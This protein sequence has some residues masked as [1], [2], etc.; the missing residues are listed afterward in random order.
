M[1]RRRN[2]NIFSLIY[3]NTF[4]LAVLRTPL[5]DQASSMQSSWGVS[6]DD[7]NV[8]DDVEYEAPD[9]RPVDWAIVRGRDGRFARGGPS[10]SAASERWMKRPLEAIIGLRDMTDALYD[11]LPATPLG[12][13]PYIM[14]QHI[15]CALILAFVERWQPETNTVHMPWGEMTIMLYDV[16]RILGIAI[17]GSLPAEPTVTTRLTV[18]WKKENG[19]G[20]LGSLRVTRR[21]RKRKREIGKGN[22][23]LG[24]GDGKGNGNW[25]SDLGVWVGITNL[26]G[27]PMSELRRR[28]AFTSGCVNVAELM[29]L[30]HR[31]Q[32]IDTQSTAYYMAIVGSTLLAD[33]TRIDMQLHAIFGVNADQ[34]EIAWGAVALVYMYRQLGMTSRAG[35]KTIAGYL[36]LLQTWIYEY[37]PAFRPHP[38]RADEPNKTRA[39]MWS[40]KKPCREVDRLRECRSILNSMTE[41]QVEWTPYMT[42]SRA[43]LNEHPRTT[44]IWGI[45]CF[46]IV[47]VYLPEWAIR[48]AWS[49]F[50]FSARI[51]EHAL[52]R[53][54]FPLEVEPSYVDWLSVCS[55]PFVVPGEGPTAGPRR[56]ESRSEYFLNEWPSRFAPL[57]RLPPVAEMNPRQ[58]HSLDVYLNDCK[59][60]FAERKTFKG[61]DPS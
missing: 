40:T 36:T 55:H 45:T 15:D 14:P 49:R 59:D 20:G 23:G 13:L 30:C 33:K 28:G 56:T 5:E 57:A 22:V 47:E 29:Q 61:Q 4:P 6:S 60:L 48:Q 1:N 35:C 46:D 53:A 38:R 3:A 26:F 21:R 12:R 50:P 34:D 10:F 25:V 18:D 2:I 42:D 7:D 16:Q 58:R 19:D 24:E 52:R 9:F 17:E 41:T 11:V 32:S 31:S 37:F 8:A 39:E 27:E 51:G 44:F 54:F 43:L